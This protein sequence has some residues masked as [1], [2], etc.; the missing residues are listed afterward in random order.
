MCVLRGLPRGRNV[1][2]DGAARFSRNG[3][4][5]IEYLTSPDGRVFTRQNIA[6]EAVPG[7]G[8]AGLYDPH[9]SPVDGE[10]YIVYS[11]TPRV[12]KTD[13]FF[14]HTTIPRV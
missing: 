9:P 4:G 5:G 1:P 6:L 10:K 14:I 8:E 7:T 2:Y 13:T 3:R 11:G 12:Q